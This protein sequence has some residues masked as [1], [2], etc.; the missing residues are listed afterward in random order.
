MLIG[1]RNHDYGRYSIEEL[2][3]MIREKGFDSAQLV[4]PKAFTE[5]SSYEEA[6]DEIL[7]KIKE[8][9]DREQI[10]IGV[11]GCYMDFGNPDEKVRKKAVDTFKRVL[12]YG[13]I[14]EA[15]TVGTETA[16]PRLSEEEKKIW[17]PHMVDSLE[18]IVE[19]AEKVQQKIGLE[20]VHWHPLDSVEVTEKVF[21]KFNSEYL[22]MIFDPVNLLKF[23]PDVNQKPYLKE[24]IDRLGN[25]IA[26]LHTKNFTRDEKG[27]YC[28][29]SLEEGIID[30][31]WIFEWLRKN[32]PDV[33]IIR[34]EIQPKNSEKDVKYIKDLWE[35]CT[36]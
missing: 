4:L 32:R 12:R 18:Q 23:K 22:K 26:V 31:T 24:W 20:P 1:T 10:R 30:Y 25:E 3:K 17:Y 34:E 33:V 13:K 16:F 36:F 6:T 5:I 7:Q 11:L 27:E 29:S 35:R 8:S 15:E 14:L 2:P 19:E 21:K 28:P 9:F